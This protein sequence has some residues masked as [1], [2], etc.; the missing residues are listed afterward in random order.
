MPSEAARGSKDIWMYGI[1]L[2]FLTDAV[3]EARHSKC[4]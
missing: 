1:G 4:S 3:I 2:S